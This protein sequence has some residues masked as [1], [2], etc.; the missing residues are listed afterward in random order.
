MSENPFP[1]DGLSDQE[2]EAARLR[3]GINALKRKGSGTFWPALKDTVTEPMFLL[4]ATACTIYFILR[5]FA[6]GFFMLVAI[7]L[8]S[9]ISFYQDSRSRKALAALRAYTQPLATV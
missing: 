9:A 4:L 6:E 1:F 5:E 3:Y 2:V 8:V 7:V